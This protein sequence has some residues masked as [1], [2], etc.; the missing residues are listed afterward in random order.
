M[1]KNPRPSFDKRRWFVGLAAVIGVVG[2]LVAIFNGVAPY[3]TP[4]PAASVSQ[5]TEIILD[6]S[7]SMARRLDDGTTRLDLA[8]KAVDRVL[9]HEIDGDNLAFREF[10]GACP[11]GVTHAPPTL[12]FSQENAQR[13]RDEIKGL[14]AKGKATLVAGLRDAIA[15]FSDETRFK[16]LGKRIIVITGNLDACG[17]RFEHDVVDKLNALKKGSDSKIVL[18]LDFIGIGLE[19]A[20]RSK[21]D[22]YAE[23]TGGAAHFADD[24]QQLDNVIE[25]IEVARV[26]RDGNA[27]SGALNASAK[28]LSP[29]ITGL[30]N[31]DY[32]AAERGLQTA[33]EE[34]ARSDIPFQG[35][36]KR[37][38]SEERSALRKAQYG[39]IYQAASRSRELQSQVI[40]LTETMLSQAKSSDE[41]ALK[42]SVD[43]Y[44]EIAAAYNQSDDD[45]QALLKQLEAMARSP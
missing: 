26:M 41:S 20:A 44:E 32:A 25:I 18:D 12:S 5:N 21:Y 13:V 33:R 2:G 6:R 19:P 22:E 11:D 28:L 14:N 35:L 38:S 24:L 17:D 40:S 45:L 39:R 29:A 43:K 31:R 37:Q 3:F 9:G 4:K 16:G 30:R 7:E 27:V 42:A 36:L 34:L 10:G 1:S 15:D 23:Q 8:R